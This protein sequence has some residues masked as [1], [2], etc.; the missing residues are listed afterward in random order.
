MPEKN[1]PLVGNVKSTSRGYAHWHVTVSP[2]GMALPV[3]SVSADNIWAPSRR[4]SSNY[5]ENS[6]G[7]RERHIFYRG[8]GRFRGPVSVKSDEQKI[9]V[10]NLS[11]EKIP[12]AWVL[13]SDGSGLGVVRSLGPILPNSVVS[14]FIDSGL[15][16]GENSLDVLNKYIDTASVMI[17]TELEK[18][19]LFKLEAQAMIDTWKNSYLRSSGSRVL[20]IAPQTYPDKLLP[21]DI[22]P[23]PSGIKRVLV[24]RV[25]LLLQSEVHLLA[26]ATN[27]I[28]F[29]NSTDDKYFSY[30]KGLGRFAE[31]KIRYVLSE[32]L[33]SANVDPGRTEKWILDNLT[34]Q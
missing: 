34:Y 11:E 8:L 3:P 25:E 27:Q 19:G 17:T 18:A 28:I 30:L 4:V 24:G 13:R 23:R 21:M 10:E 31:S 5:V 1:L 6:N 20:Y 12:A 7:E 16:L 2:L 9:Y 22:H 33:S 26:E 15:I 29:Q 14:T 32:E